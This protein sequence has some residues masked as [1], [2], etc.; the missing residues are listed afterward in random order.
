MHEFQYAPTPDEVRRLLDAPG[1]PTGRLASYH[2]Y[3][4]PE[5]RAPVAGARWRDFDLEAGTWTLVGKNG[6]ADVFPLH[7]VLIAELRRFRSWQRSLAEKNDAMRRALADPNTAYVYLTRNGRPINPG[8]LNRVLRW[9]AIRADV[10]VVPARSRWDSPGGKTSRLSPHALRRAWAVHALN[11]P[12]NP[13]PIDVVSSA[14]RHADISTTRR[15]YADEAR[16]G[17]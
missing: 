9:R 1:S 10:G 6:K 8:T 4:A 5:R 11:D 2:L 16:T 15:H 7:P 14:L 13:V 3:Y 17:S 12:T